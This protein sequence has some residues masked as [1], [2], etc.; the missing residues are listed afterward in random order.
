LSGDDA[1]WRL[2]VPDAR[3]LFGAKKYYTELSA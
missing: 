3:L 1:P 2:D